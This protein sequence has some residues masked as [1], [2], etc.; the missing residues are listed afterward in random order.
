MKT[1]Q[2]VVLSMGLVALP[3][4]A[5]A[6]DQ[7]G[8]PSKPGRDFAPLVEKVRR[9]TWQFRDI[10]TA[11]AEGWVRGTPCVSGPNSGAM[12]VHFILPARVGDGVLDGDE[13]EAL[14]YEPMPNG[15]L[16]LV[17]VEFI[18]IAADWT[19]KNPSGGAPS[20]D[21]HLLN[22][23]GEPNRY[24]LPAFYEIHVWAWERNPNGNF[25]DWNTQVTCDQQ[26]G[27]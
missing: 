5:L 8:H 3:L 18:V 20:L 1:L 21:G 9:A 22:Y 14:I 7:F 6:V 17:G 27:E 19:A 15:G 25:A 12:G 4:A 10:N 26:P 2:R 11:T 23:V 16:R 13:P 24:G